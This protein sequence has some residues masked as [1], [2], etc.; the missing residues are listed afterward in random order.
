[1]DAREDL[2]KVSIET[3]QDWRRI[4]RNLSTALL[5]RLDLEVESHGQSGDKDALLPH[6]NE[7]LENL[8]DIARPNLRINGRTTE[9]PYE[10]EDDVEP[11]DEALDRHIWS[12]SD[13]RLKWDKEI[14]GRRR[15][16]PQEIESTML[17]SLAQHRASDLDVAEDPTTYDLMFNRFD[18]ELEQTLSNAALL[19]PQLMQSISSL[20]DRATRIK[21]VSAEVI[22]LKP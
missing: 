18:P 4:Q 20:H 7:F 5:A 1:M 14:A 8:F 15:S 19:A 3:E 17:E 11:F 6:I 13:Q 9:D 22:A 10:D 16:R 21:S 2:P 12:L